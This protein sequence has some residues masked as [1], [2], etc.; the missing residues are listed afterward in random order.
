MPDRLRQW[1]TGVVERFV[2][3]RADLVISVGHRLAALRR[4]ESGI[5]PVVISNGIDWTNFAAAR[6]G[7]GFGQSMIYV[8]N[9]SSWSGIEQNIRAMPILL[10]SIP[11]AKLIVVGSG[12]P[13]YERFLR[14]LTSE[15]GVGH[16]VEFLGSQPHE[17]L[18]ELMKRASVGLANSEPVAYR[19]YACPLKVIE[20]MA[21]GLPVV[22]TEGTEAADMLRHYSC[23]IVTPYEPEQIA[24]AMQRLLSDRES[25]EAFRAAAL[26]ESEM[27]DWRQLLSRERKLIENQLSLWRERQ[28][29]ETTESPAE[30]SLTMK[31]AN[32]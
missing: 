13:E 28:T 15:L 32:L 2:Q 8:G 18:G 3:R 27:L 12:L 21:S 11:S 30:I 14:Q 9:L 17:R 16:A 7:P 1:Y 6:G 24:G 26:R 19:Q 22:A 5:N 23:G 20:Y 4:R 10:R 31:E 25:Y 29:P